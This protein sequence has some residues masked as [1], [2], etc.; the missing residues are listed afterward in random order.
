MISSEITVPYRTSQ[1][2]AEKKFTIYRTHRGPIVRASDGKW[3]S[4]RLMHQP[5]Q[6]LMQSWLRTKARDEGA[7]P[8]AHR[9]A[10]RLGS[11]L[12]S[13]FHRHRARRILG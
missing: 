13:R 8:R 3:V 4:I 6:S 9:T 11:P 1:G 7:T 5:V 2:V 10:S 12:G